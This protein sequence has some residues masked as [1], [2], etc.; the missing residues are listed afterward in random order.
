LAGGSSFNWVEKAEVQLINLMIEAEDSREHKTNMAAI[1]T[2][3]H[4]II[5]IGKHIHFS[6]VPI[7]QS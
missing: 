5:G 2:L 4:Y 7:A 6:E 1:Q 3:T